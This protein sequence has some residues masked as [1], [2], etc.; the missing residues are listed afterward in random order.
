MKVCICL[1]VTALGLLL[2]VRLS[3][4]GAPLLEVLRPLKIASSVLLKLCIKIKSFVSNR[5]SL[6][7]DVSSSVL[8]K[9]L[10][11]S[12]RSNVERAVSSAKVESSTNSTGA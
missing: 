7:V 8:K 3:E 11:V 4:T 5:G 6:A 9:G 1:G 12:L 10:P 2:K